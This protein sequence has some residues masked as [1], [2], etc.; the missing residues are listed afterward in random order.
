MKFVDNCVDAGIDMQNLK[1]A[2]IQNM[3]TSVLRE[4]ST[5]STTGVFDLSQTLDSPFPLVSIRNADNSAGVTQL[6]TCGQFEYSLSISDTLT[7]T[8]L[9]VQEVNSLISLT[10]ITPNAQGYYTQLEI[11]LTPTL[12]S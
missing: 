9:S 12:N 4:T 2:S 3:E 5:Q 8:N 7:G 10:P 1:G 11:A 6:G